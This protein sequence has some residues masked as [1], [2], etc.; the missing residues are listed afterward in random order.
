MN[1]A[2]NAIEENTIP[3]THSPNLNLWTTG[4]SLEDNPQKGSIF[5]KLMAK[6]ESFY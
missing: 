3:A 6:W 5:I 1:S 2:F 4:N